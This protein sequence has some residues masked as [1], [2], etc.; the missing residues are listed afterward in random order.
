MCNAKIY[1]TDRVAFRILM[2]IK[3]Y[4]PPSDV[5]A[6]TQNIVESSCEVKG[7]WQDVPLSDPRLKF[8]V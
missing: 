6:R 7:N 8:K 4:K 1:V 2:T 3:G 5:A